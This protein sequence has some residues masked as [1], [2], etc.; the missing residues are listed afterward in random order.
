MEES[1]A[2]E[3][4]ILLK[5]NV[6]TIYSLLRRNIATETFSSIENMKAGLAVGATTVEKNMDRVIH[7]WSV[8]QFACNTS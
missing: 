2:I 4:Q 8:L 5:F 6:V 7:S 1:N 3:P